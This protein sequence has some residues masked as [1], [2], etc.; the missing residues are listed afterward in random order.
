MTQGDLSLH[1]GNI[2]LLPLSH[3]SLPCSLLPCSLEVSGWGQGME[4]CGTHCGSA[5]LRQAP[6]VPMTVSAL[7]SALL[8]EGVGVAAL[9]VQLSAQWSSRALPLK[10]KEA[11]CIWFPWRH[12]RPILLAGAQR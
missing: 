6:F 1:T 3:P 4:R 7:G 11:L 10:L 5:A 12:A 2:P 9:G 8:A